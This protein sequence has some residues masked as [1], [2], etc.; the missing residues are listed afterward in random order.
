MIFQK[1]DL[2]YS[3]AHTHILQI[4]IDF[5]EIFQTDPDIEVNKSG[6][7]ISLRLEEYGVK[8]RDWY[9]A[10][11]SECFVYNENIRSHL[12]LCTRYLNGGL[13]C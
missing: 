5:P 3:T 9:R 13:C 6:Q 4:F 8:W 2:L 12:C 7:D 10:K 1:I 11:K